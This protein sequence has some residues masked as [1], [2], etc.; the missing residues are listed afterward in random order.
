M[1][2]DVAIEPLGES[3]YAVWNVR[4]KCLLIQKGL[5]ACTEMLPPDGDEEAKTKDAKA[6]ATILLNVRDQH[7][8]SL[9]SHDT[10]ASM[11]AQ[12]ASIYKAKSLARRLQ[13][14]KELT[15]LRMDPSESATAYLDRGRA[16]ST[17]LCASGHTVNEDD[18][19][20][21]VLAGLPKAYEATVTFLEMADKVP[22][23][24]DLLPK[25]LT[26]EQR[27]HCHE[28]TAL[29][30]RDGKKTFGGPG[31]WRGRRTYSNT[32]QDSWRPGGA[33]SS[34]S[35]DK[36]CYYCHKKGH[37]KAECRQR[38]RD[39]G[40]AQP[41]AHTAVALM[42][43]RAGTAQQADV[44][45]IDSGASRH[46]TPHK[47]L[48]NDYKDMDCAVSIMFG[49]GD[50]E[51]AAGTGTVEMTTSVAGRTTKMT[52][53]DVLYVP[54]ATINLFS[55]KQATKHGATVQFSTDQ[56]DITKTGALVARATCYGGLFAMRTT[57]ETHVERAYLAQPIE[58]PELWH[59]RFGHLGYGSLSKLVR[60]DMVNGIG[61]KA[62]EFNEEKTKLC[63]PCELSKAH[64]G[65]YP[66]STHT[67]ATQPLHLVHMDVC[68]PMPTTSLGGNRYFA[69][70]LDDFTGLSVVRPVAHKSDVPEVVKQVITQ[71]EARSGHRVRNVRTDRGG[72]YLNKILD[73]FYAE[74]GI[75]HQ[76]TA[77]YTP[78]QNGAAERL[79]RTL[80]ER[81]RAMLEENKISTA[82]WAEAVATANYIR[83]RSPSLDRIR[84]P[85]ELF[86]QTKPDVSGLRVFGAKAYV[87]V[88]KA[89]RNKLQPVSEKGILVGYEPESKAYRVLL[90]TNKIKISADVTFDEAAGARAAPLPSPRSL[91]NN[92]S[93][94]ELDT[95]QPVA[96]NDL[97]EPGTEDFQDV[98]D[99]EDPVPAPATVNKYN[100]RDRAT[101]AKPLWRANVAQVLAEPLTYEEAMSSPD[102]KL[103]K[104]AMDEEMGSLWANKTYEL[105]PL[106]HGSR[107]IAAKWIFKIK[108]DANGHTERYK[109]RLV[110]KG[111]MQREG[112]D[113]DEVYAPVSKHTTLRTMLSIVAAQDLELRQLD[114]TTA[115]LNG[116]LEEDIYMKQ[117]PG[118][119]TGG[120]NT[121][122]HLKR[123][124][125]GLRQAPRA[126]HTRLKLELEKIGLHASEADPGLFI[127][128]QEDMLYLLVYVDDI[129]VACKQPSTAD[130]VVAQLKSAFDVR[131]LGP[132]KFFIGIEIT[133][134]RGAHSLK[135]GQRRMVSEL[136]AKYALADCNPRSTPLSTSTKLI[137]EEDNP[138][139]DPAYSELVGSLLYLSVCTRPDIA[140][141]VGVLSRFMSKPSATHFTA[142]K[143]V[144]RYLAGTPDY[145]ITYKPGDTTE[146]MGYCD[147][148]YAGD[149]DTRRSTTGYAFLLNSGI[150]SW[151]SRRQPTVAVST[152]EAEY[153]A[154]A[155]AVKEALWLRKL[156]NDF[157]CATGTITIFCD[158]QSAIKLLKN[159]V[160]SA[161][162]KHI[163]VIYHFARERVARKEVDFSYCSTHDMVADSLTKALPDSGFAAC[164]SGMGMG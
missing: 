5:W 67:K 43:T 2:N 138:L 159:Y 36:E 101:I 39:E 3:N 97:P 127:L 16:L 121:V 63:E 102:S 141:A 108:R 18:V 148:D 130:K 94:D 125:Y 83:N 6:K 124:L 12:L 96:N 155:A 128:P 143:G 48:L 55:V 41:N 150:I 37:I 98:N 91:V 22:S 92:D 54:K 75:V 61:V 136:L 74:K 149:L 152:T 114:V 29:Y 154:A 26:V 122:C 156:F 87:H 51:E 111:F 13:L 146:L 42:A 117:P 60:G 104:Q 76:K 33:S 20:L 142:A 59:R 84:T 157:N 82:L 53:L 131:D 129:L 14:R 86:N 45:T 139:D 153:M 135:I 4:I 123:A 93:E 163:D 132:A 64:R 118:Y 27:Q 78:E 126:W 65:P 81:V 134:D 137:N 49:N 35:K 113:F 31:D 24:N 80:M 56:C 99:E 28:E 44:W 25:L 90:D 30:T 34:N 23:L 9:A 145:G 119:E 8:A 77:P 79:N 1:G 89:R 107:A 7:L 158:N 151:S 52:L 110:V 112:V 147:A 58:T 164:R 103:W 68:G 140:H 116:E 46:V 105:G 40:A 70:F 85:W 120:P 115:F 88:P 162:S 19:V 133:R 160:A 21:A 57:Y 32:K 11:W 100:L 72:E 62:E 47:H 69:T 95:R 15:N 10:A 38:L 144:L 109:A 71:L 73:S 161:R 17:E 50:T 106:P 66:P